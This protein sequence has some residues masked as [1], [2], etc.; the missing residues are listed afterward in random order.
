MNPLALKILGPLLGAAL[1][2]GVGAYGAARVLEPRVDHWRAAA[3]ANAKN[4]AAWE[5]S[6][7]KSEQLRDAETAQAV[8]AYNQLSGQCEARVAAA[9]K[10]AL[11]IHALI[12][13]DP[14]RDPQGCPVRQLVDPAG[15][16]DALGA[17]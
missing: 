9:R 10:S 15:L 17:R 13:K 5:V 1:L 16:R 3:A 11:A 8:A 2:M 12:E 6:F 4:A 14:P 7:R